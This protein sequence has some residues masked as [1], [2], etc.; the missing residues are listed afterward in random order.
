MKVYLIRHGHAV[1]E[2]G[3]ISDE[4]RYLTKKGRKTV[5]EVG[6]VLKEAGVE[7]DA[8]LTSPL[9]RAV[10]TAGEPFSGMFRL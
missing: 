3:T 9:V 10:Q 2:S 4:Q 5:R 6:R 8:V 1:D 7:L